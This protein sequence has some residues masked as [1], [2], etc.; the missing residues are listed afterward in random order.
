VNASE[1]NARRLGTPEN[2]R[3]TGVLRGGH[4]PEIGKATQFKPGQTGNP[5][6]RPK[7][8][9]IDKALEEALLEDDSRLALEIAC[10][11]LRKARKGDVR[12]IQLAAER[13]EGKARQP[14]D[15]GNADGQPFE[16]TVRNIGRISEPRGAA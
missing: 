9:L 16:I 2:S 10:A 5:G 15:L 7:K 6:G 11:L 3:K 8:T 1:R 13:T 14:T 4:S 12:A